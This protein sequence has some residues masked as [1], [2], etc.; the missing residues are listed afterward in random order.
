MKRRLVIVL[1]CLALVGAAVAVKVGTDLR[2]VRPDGH[3]SPARPEVGPDAQKSGGSAN[4]LA[5]EQNKEA[6]FQR[7][8]WRRPG[9]GD[10]ILHA[11][12]RDWKDAGAAVQKWQWFV[13][14]APSPEFRRWLLED[15]PFELAPP[16]APRC[17]G[18]SARVVSAQGRAGGADAVSQPR[19]T[20]GG[21][22]RSEVRPDICR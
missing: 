22:S 15:N 7:A 11:E 5:V 1:A 8:F 2:A 9:A 19:R 12:R 6:V 10:R 13:A 14:V 3:V 16:R 17:R 18:E 21:V 4:T 20:L